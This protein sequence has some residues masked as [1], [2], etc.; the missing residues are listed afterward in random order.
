MKT[1]FWQEKRSVVTVNKYQQHKVAPRWDEE[2]I[3]DP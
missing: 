2:D 1:L 3:D